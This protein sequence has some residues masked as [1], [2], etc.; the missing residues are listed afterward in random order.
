MVKVKKDLTGMVFGRLTVIEQAEDYVNPNDGKRIAR[1]LCK[2]SCQE[3]RYI[4]TNGTNLTRGLTKSCGCYAKE[5]TSAAKLIDLTGKKF[6]R[7]TVINRSKNDYVYKGKIYPR[8]NCI[9]DCGTPVEVLGDELRSGNSKSC[10]CYASERTAARNKEMFKLYNDIEDH[11]KYIIM[12]TSKKEPIYI[13]AE[14]YT[15]VKDIYW[16]IGEGNYIYGSL[17]GEKYQLHRLIMDCPD[18]LVVD[19]IGGDLT[20]N[21]NRKFN[22]RYATHSQNTQ[23]VKL[24]PKNKTGVTG[25]SWDSTKQKWMAGITKDRHHHTIGRYDKFEDAVE[26]RL[27]AEDEY[28]GEFSYRNSQRIYKEGLAQYQTETDDGFGNNPMEVQS[29]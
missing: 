14:D 11:G 29:A 25:V 19:H 7:L 27:K 28:F 1:W 10:G 26:A 15:K 6:G 23:N 3:D 24:H 21:D 18:D 4:T 16:F 20:R 5:M 12:Y 8:W 22:L 9:C 17:E 2:C 13:D